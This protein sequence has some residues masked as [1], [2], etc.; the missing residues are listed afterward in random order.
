MTKEEERSI[1]EEQLFEP[2][3]EAPPMEEGDLLRARVEELE[4]LAE[5][6]RAEAARA[7]ADLFNYRQ[8]VER[9]RARV[10]HAALEDLVIRLLPVM[11]N[12]DRALAAGEDVPAKDLRNGVSMVQRQFLQALADMGVI[13][14]EALGQPFDPAHHEAVALCE[15]PEGQEDCVL[16]EI[17]KGYCLDSRVIRPAKVQVG[18]KELI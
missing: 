10:R 11:D 15:A 1:G 3:A 12:L 18:K 5:G 4:A 2:I 13:P 8:R 7:K 9:E 16:C 14:I 6:L 17:Q